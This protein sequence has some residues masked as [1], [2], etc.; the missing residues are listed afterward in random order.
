MK[1]MWCTCLLWCMFC[2]HFCSHFCSIIG[3][4]KKRHEKL[5]KE[6]RKGN[7]RAICAHAETVRRKHSFDGSTTVR[8][9][10][11]EIC[12]LVRDSSSSFLTA[13]IASL[14]LQTLEAGSTHLRTVLCEWQRGRMIYVWS[15]LGCKVISS[16]FFKYEQT[17]LMPFLA[18]F[19]YELDLI[20]CLFGNKQMLLQ[21]L[22]HLRDNSP[23]PL[24][25]ATYLTSCLELRA[26]L[27]LRTWQAAWSYVKAEI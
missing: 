21:K 4:N 15:G 3:N 2:S 1:R 24:L 6:S 11:V 9:S 14:V 16:F 12:K 20:T 26:W 8:L 19:H 13:S 7:M 22:Y 18:R 23:W 27:E 5:S 17:P 25:G 10:I